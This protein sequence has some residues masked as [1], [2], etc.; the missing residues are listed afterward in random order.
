MG[1]QRM[2]ADDKAPKPTPEDRARR[3]TWNEGDLVFVGRDEGKPKP[4][5]ESKPKK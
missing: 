3:F 4:K 1:H 5:P 2:P